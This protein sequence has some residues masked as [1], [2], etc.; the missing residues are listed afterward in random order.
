MILTLFQNPTNFDD[1]EQFKMLQMPPNSVPIQE[2][3]KESESWSRPH[4]DKEID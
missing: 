3:Y 4:Q 2:P 1:S